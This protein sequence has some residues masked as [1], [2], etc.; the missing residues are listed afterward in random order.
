MCRSGTHRM[1]APNDADLTTGTGT[2][3]HQLG[4][5]LKFGEEKHAYARCRTWC[6]TDRSTET[7]SSDGAARTT[8]TCG[9]L[10]RPRPCSTS[11]STAAFR[12]AALGYRDSH[13]PQR[14]LRF[15]PAFRQKGQAGA[16]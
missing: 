12:R 7:I 8:S 11:V 4:A 13:L 16:G 2:E 6:H 10:A 3:R 15:D 5:H 14:D 9:A 1:R